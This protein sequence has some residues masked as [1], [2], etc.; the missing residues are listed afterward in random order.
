MANKLVRFHPEAEQEYLSSLSWYYERSPSAALDFESEFQRGVSVVT[1]SPERWPTYFL[2]FRRYIL[3]Q[4]PFSIVYQVLEEEI[5]V[6]AIAHAH[7]KPGY[8]INRLRQ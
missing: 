4:F 6:L 8:W 7:R 3:H 2:C 5:L 1:E